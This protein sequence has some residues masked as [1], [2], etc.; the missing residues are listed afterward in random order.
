[1]KRCPQCNRLE[2]DEALKFCRADGATLISESGSVSDDAGTAKFISAAVSSEI[3]T[4]VLPR[5]TDAEIN[6]PTAPT[7]FLPATASP[8][9]TRELTRPK[10][11]GVVFGLFAVV[12]LVFASTIR[13]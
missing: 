7:T 12:I 13:T 5:R 8:S 9:S 4:S 6:R 2:T 10:R 11:R 1:M 3:E